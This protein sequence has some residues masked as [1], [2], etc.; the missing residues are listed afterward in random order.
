[1]T[2]VLCWFKRVFDTEAAEY[3]KN[4]K[5][6]DI[7]RPA[8][9][10]MG[11]YERF[12]YFDKIL[13][14][15]ACGIF[16]NIAKTGIDAIDDQYVGK[17]PETNNF[18]IMG[19]IGNLATNIAAVTGGKVSKPYKWTNYT[20][21]EDKKLAAT[22]L[23]SLLTLGFLDSTIPNAREKNKR[24]REEVNDDPLTALLPALVS[25]FIM[26]Q[27]EELEK[28]CIRTLTR[29][30]SQREELRYGPF[31]MQYKNNRD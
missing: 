12:R 9:E 15:F 6:D 2:N 25:A 1:M 27:D 26:I 13:K 3:R 31:T 4:Y 23:D 19:N 11:D 30:F 21:T 16:P 17:K 8:G 18:D 7:K 5:T 29:V 28:R 20:S 22:D 14:E 24:V 10:L